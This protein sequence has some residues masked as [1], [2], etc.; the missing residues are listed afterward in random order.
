MCWVECMGA[1]EWEGD[2]DRLFSKSFHAF[3]SAFRRIF[4][5]SFLCSIFLVSKTL[6]KLH[7][8]TKYLRIQ[9][10]IWWILCITKINSSRIMITDVLGS[11]FCLVLSG[12]WIRKCK[13]DVFV[14]CILQQ[15]WRK[16]LCNRH[17]VLCHVFRTVYFVSAGNLYL[18]SLLWLLQSVVNSDTV[19]KTL[20]SN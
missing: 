17:H 15:E 20:L 10:R 5:N 2:G 16:I 12:W 13:S 1:T 4:P 19:S 9:S 14:V 7:T 18:C 6:V 8:K 3:W 11:Q